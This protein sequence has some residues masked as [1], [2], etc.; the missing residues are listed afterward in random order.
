MSGGYEFR[1]CDLPV[2]AAIDGGR[3]DFIDHYRWSSGNRGKIWCVKNAD[4]ILCISWRFIFFKSFITLRIQQVTYTE[5]T[6]FC[7]LHPFSI[8]K[9]L[10]LKLNRRVIILK[11]I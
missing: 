1:L 3:E 4:H 6:H 11:Q 9:F 7:Y 2:S 5:Y 8:R 10:N